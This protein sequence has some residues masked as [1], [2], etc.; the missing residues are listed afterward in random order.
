MVRIVQEVG[1]Q[2]ALVQKR[3]GN[4][5]V[6]VLCMDGK[7]RLCNIPKKFTGKK[8]EMVLVDS[9]LLVGLRLFETNTL[10]CD[11]LEVYTPQEITILKKMDGPWH[12]F[13][14]EKESSFIPIEHSVAVELDT[15]VNFDDI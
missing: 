7:T 9:W 5:R 15:E 10:K 1:E 6:S 3:L 14:V 2:Y 4:G 13:G 12:L 11:V 8:K